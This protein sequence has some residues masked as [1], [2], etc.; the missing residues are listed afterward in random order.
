VP[1]IALEDIGFVAGDEDMYDL[2]H[3]NWTG[4]EKFTNALA[5]ALEKYVRPQGAVEPSAAR[6]GSAAASP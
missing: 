5:M 1:F 3:L 4:A 2:G 6:A